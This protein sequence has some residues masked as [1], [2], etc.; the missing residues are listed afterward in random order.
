[1]D[2]SAVHLHL[3]LNHLPLFGSV[4]LIVALIW[5]FV[6]HSRAIVRMALWLAV[7]L[8]PITFVVMKTGDGAEDAVERVIPRADRPLIH[9][10][11][12]AGEVANWVALATM[13]VAAGALWLT[14][15]REDAR[16]AASVAALVMLIATFGVVAYA[17]LEGGQIRHTELRQPS[18][19]LPPEATPAP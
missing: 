13:A 19:V 12:E 9:D 17:A 15:R 2:L 3:M 14:R 18:A 11:E 1:M 7:V 5:G 6:T 16:S 8:G 4:F 10:H